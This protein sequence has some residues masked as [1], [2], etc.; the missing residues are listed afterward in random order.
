M[1]SEIEP[2]R[3]IVTGSRRFDSSRETL[4]QDFV[5]TTLERVML[6]LVSDESV[7]VLVEG[8]CPCGGV[9][10]VAREWGE[11]VGVALSGRL[12]VEPHPADFKRLGVQAGPIR[13]RLMASLG[14]RMCLGFPLGKS[15]RGTWGMLQEAADAGIACR[16][17]PLPRR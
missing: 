9:D 11:R 8:E 12:T 13:N 15:S 6:P 4:Q 10:Q 5:R 1:P 7:V 3:I 14:A 2:T 17:Y 16:V